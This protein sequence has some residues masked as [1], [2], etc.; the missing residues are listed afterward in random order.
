MFHSYIVFNM[1]KKTHE[2]IWGEGGGF[3]S[4]HRCDVQGIVKTVSRYHQGLG[5]SRASFRAAYWTPLHPPSKYPPAPFLPHPYCAHHDS[6]NTT[7]NNTPE[8]T[9]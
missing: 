1:L 2:V 9:R 7:E 8:N 4:S 5:S 6:A 3:K